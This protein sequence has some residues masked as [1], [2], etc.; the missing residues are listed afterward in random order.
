MSQRLESDLDPDQRWESCT[1]H[2]ARDIS[3]DNIEV[4][5]RLCTIFALF[6]SFNV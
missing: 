4:P 5:A 6:A 3:T 2:V 1:I